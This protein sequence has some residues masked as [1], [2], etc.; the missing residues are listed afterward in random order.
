MT[1]AMRRCFQWAVVL[2]LA[3]GL[4]SCATGPDAPRWVQG[5]PPKSFPDRQ[6]TW[7][8]GSGAQPD[9]AAAAAVAEVARKTSGEREGA[10]VERTWVDEQ[11]KVH[12]ALAVLDRTAEIERFKGELAA[13]D[14]RLA[15]T[16]A[17]LDP[18]ASPSASFGVL[19]RAV[20]LA[21]AREALAT[22][23]VRLGGEAPPS[24]PT[25]T[26]AELEEQL[27]S[28]RHSLTIDVEAWETDSK[29]GLLGDPLEEIRVAM[30]QAVLGRGFR[31]QSSEGWTTSAGWLLVRARVGIDRLDLGASDRFVAV[32]WK[33]I[34][35]INDRTGDGESLAILTREGRSTHLNDPEARREARKQAEAFVVEALSSWMDEWTLPRS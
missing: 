27:A 25:R 10:Q 18:D 9:E 21:T 11:A 29:S 35:E 31:I 26:R 3:S 7:G 14:A 12:W 23:I 20:E 19:L 17:P 30:A 33:A 1:T 6:Y 5:K 24:D 22:R 34:V 2:G 8:V 15:E 13:T 32:E 16:L 28:L 4:A